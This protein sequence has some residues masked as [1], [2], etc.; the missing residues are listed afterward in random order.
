MNWTQV[1]SVRFHTDSRYPPSSP[2]WKTLR[3]SKVPPRWSLLWFRDKWKRSMFQCIGWRE[4]I[5]DTMIFL[6]NLKIYRHQSMTVSTVRKGALKR[7]TCRNMRTTLLFEV[8]ILHT[9]TNIYIYIYIYIWPILGNLQ[10]TWS[11]RPANQ[12]NFETMTHLWMIYLSKIVVSTTILV[13][14]RVVVYET[15]KVLMVADSSKIGQS[16]LVWK[17]GNPKLPLVLTYPRFPNRKTCFLYLLGHIPFL[18]SRARCPSTLKFQ[19]TPVLLR[20]ESLWDRQKYHPQQGS[21]LN[22]SLK[23]TE[24][25]G[26][27]KAEIAI[28]DPVF[29]LA[30]DVCW[31]QCS[32]WGPKSFINPD[33]GVA[34][35]K[36]MDGGPRF[37]SPNLH[38]NLPRF[39]SPGQ[40]WMKFPFLK[41]QICR[42]CFQ[43]SPVRL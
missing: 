30:S 41:G 43:T 31:W 36:C 5:K 14:H 2:L 42:N 33:P 16:R 6:T 25:H 34:F 3:W 7:Q 9:Y 18:S 23:A 21:T 39:E 32:H 17:W 19:I 35:T 24:N 40:S 13:Y 37:S 4:H 29:L 8:R 38:G 27:F 1:Y 11:Y 12:H 22:K 26:Y 28:L 10:K 20:K 15:S